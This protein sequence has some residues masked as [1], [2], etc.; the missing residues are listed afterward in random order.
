[1]QRDCLVWRQHRAELTQRLLFPVCSAG[2]AP[3]REAGGTPSVGG[4]LL[5]EC[6]AAGAGGDGDGVEGPPEVGVDRPQAVVRLEQQQ[7]LARHAPQELRDLA[8][9]LPRVPLQLL[10]VLHR[11]A[12]RSACAGGHGHLPR[13]SHMHAH[14]PGR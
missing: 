2:G 14:T 12:Q 4:T 7:E 5:G 13:M 10:V 9:V 3:E 11:S 8:L 6:S 1:M